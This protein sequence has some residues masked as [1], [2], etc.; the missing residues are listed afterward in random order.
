MVVFL[1]LPPGECYNNWKLI[2]K[3]SVNYMCEFDFRKYEVKTI[4]SFFIRQNLIKI[5]II[6]N[7]YF[8]NEI[9]IKLKFISGISSIEIN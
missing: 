8:Y 1:L 9:H 7:N 6:I 3:M 2:A 4:F 5:T